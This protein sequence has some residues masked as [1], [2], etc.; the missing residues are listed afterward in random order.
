MNKEIYELNEK[1]TYEQNDLTEFLENN[2]NELVTIIF[3]VTEIPEDL[4]SWQGAVF[5]FLGVRSKLEKNLCDF[6]S[7][8]YLKALPRREATSIKEP[9]LKCVTPANHKPLCITDHEGES[10]EFFS[11]E[12]EE[13]FGSLSLSQTEGKSDNGNFSLIIQEKK[14]NNN[15]AIIVYSPELENNDFSSEIILDEVIEPQLPLLQ[16][17]ILGVVE[18]VL[19]NYTKSLREEEPRK[20]AVEAVGGLLSNYGV[21]EVELWITQVLTGFGISENPLIA[22]LRSTFVECLAYRFVEVIEKLATHQPRAGLDLLESLLLN[23]IDLTKAHLHIQKDFSDILQDYKNLVLLDEAYGWRDHF[24][25][26]QFKIASNKCDEQAP[27]QLRSARIHDMFTFSK[28]DANQ[29]HALALILKI[30]LPKGDLNQICSFLTRTVGNPMIDF[31]RKPRKDVQEKLQE[32]LTKHFGQFTEELLKATGLNKDE[33]IGFGNFVD[34]NKIRKETVPKLLLDAYCM[35]ADLEERPLQKIQD[36]ILIRFIE[37]YSKQEKGENFAKDSILFGNV[38]Q[39]FDERRFLKD[40]EV[41]LFADMLAQAGYTWFSAVNYYMEQQLVVSEN[42]D[43]ALMILDPNNKLPDFCVSL[44]NKILVEAKKKII[45]EV[46]KA[47]KPFYMPAYNAVNQNE[48]IH[49]FAELYLDSILSCILT[50]LAC[51]WGERQPNG[52]FSNILKMTLQ[53]I[54]SCKSNEFDGTAMTKALL[55]AIGIEK[56][57]DL[58]LFVLPFGNGKIEQMAFDEVEKQLPLLLNELYAGF[59]I[60]NET[61]EVL[62]KIQEHGAL[63]SAILSK[64]IIPMAFRWMGE[65]KIGYLLLIQLRIF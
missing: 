29:I 45:K 28:C 60:P 6:I 12:S 4:M 20:K 30:P 38:I 11:L 24:L 56:P 37:E 3:K 22:Q 54:Q 47:N 42:I 58:Q 5:K 21:T 65:K 63:D 41:K 57:S 23:S 33:A 49:T 2:I 43:E 27:S 52:L 61:Q 14:P 39:A 48:E 44:R 7:N 9:S 16:R 8:F 18:V 40:D 55:K 64:N 34:L 50:K 36:L 32:Y 46:E 19:F 26:S 51:E 59:L 35:V 13:E 25:Q 17:G 31:F 15:N 62:E 10:T 53:T 1:L